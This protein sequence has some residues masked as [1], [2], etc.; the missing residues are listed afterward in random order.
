MRYF[1]IFMLGGPTAVAYAIKL[2][3]IQRRMA[4]IQLL[5]D[6][7]HELHQ[8]H[9]AELNEAREQT[10]R[11]INKLLDESIQQIAQYVDRE[12]E[13][14]RALVSELHAD[15]NTLIGMHFGTS[16][17]AAKFRAHCEKEAGVHA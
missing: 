12:K 11:D 4:R 2:S 13:V 17:S 9:L 7:E 10:T 14:H 1:R 16:I 5:L 3:W 8:A 6:R 15:M